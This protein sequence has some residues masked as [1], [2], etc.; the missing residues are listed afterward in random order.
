LEN[1]EIFIRIG[2]RLNKRPSCC[3]YDVP[4]RLV[5]NMFLMSVTLRHGGN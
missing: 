1:L 3:I 5:K 4:F 2:A